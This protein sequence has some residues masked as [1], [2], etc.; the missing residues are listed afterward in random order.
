MTAVC[1]FIISFYAGIFSW[2]GDWW[3]IPAVLI[4]CVA[5][6]VWMCWRIARLS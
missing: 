5:Y 6:T 1:G 4:P 2:L 3:P